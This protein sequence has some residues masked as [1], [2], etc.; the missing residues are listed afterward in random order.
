MEGSVM[1]VE[2]AVLLIL[3]LM[4]IGMLVF[5]YKDEKRVDVSELPRSSL[6]KFI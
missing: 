1:L 6:D 4:G 3:L 2:I 5:D